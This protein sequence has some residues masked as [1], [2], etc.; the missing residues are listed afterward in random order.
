MCNDLVDGDASMR[1]TNFSD[2]RSEHDPV[3]ND[4]G[5]GD[6]LKPQ[7]SSLVNR[8][9]GMQTNGNEKKTTFAAL[10][11]TTTWQ[12]QKTNNSVN[13]LQEVPNV[14]GS[15]LFS[16]SFGNRFLCSMLVM[17]VLLRKW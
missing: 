2:P 4:D 7:K 8:K 11:N 10:P 6:H 14:P 16:E 13:D 17:F 1:I 15:C 12:Q 5:S 9:P 3:Y